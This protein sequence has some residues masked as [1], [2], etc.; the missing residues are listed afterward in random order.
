MVAIV[1]GLATG[2]E[3]VGSGYL[4]GPQ[5]ILTAEHCTRDKKT[6]GRPRYLRVVRASGGEVGQATVSEASPDVDLAVLTIAEPWGVDVPSVAFGRVDRKHS[7]ELRGCEAIGYP[8]WQLDAGDL[9][10][11]AAELHGTIRRTEDAEG[12]YLVLRDPLLGSVTTP[13]TANDADAGPGSVW[14]GLSGALVF[15][16]GRAIGVVVEHHPRQGASAVRLVPF[17]VVARRK[18]ARTRAVALALGLRSVSALPLVE[19]DVP[20]ARPRRIAVGRDIVA[21]LVVTGDRN[22]FYVGGHHRLADAYIPATEVFERVDVDGFV[23]RDWL[24]AELD[25]FLTDQDR[26]YFIV[27][28]EAGLGKTAFLAHLVRTRGWIHHFAETA[29]GEAGVIPSRLSLAAQ[30]IR[31]YELGGADGAGATLAEGPAARPDYLATL[32]RQ[33]AERRTPGERIVVV[34]DALDQAGARPGENVLGLP[35]RVPEGVFIICSQRPVPVRLLIDGSRR[36][37]KLDADSQHNL[38]DI[39]AFL[40]EAVHRPAIS[41][42]RTAAGIDEDQLI[43]EFLARSHGLWLYLHFVLADLASGSASVDLTALPDGLSRWYYE[44]FDRWREQHLADWDRV[45]LPVLA[46]LAAVQEPV[47]AGLLRTLA[48]VDVPTSLLSGWRPLLAVRREPER[49]YRLYHQSLVEFVE[50][51]FQPDEIAEQDFADDLSAATLAGHSR[52]ADRYITL[53]GGLEAGLTGL[54]EPAVRGVDGGYGL[55]HLVAHLAAAGRDDD[56]DS[57]LSISWRR[58]DDDK[59]IE[60]A[61]FA[62][63]DAAGTLPGFLGD[64]LIAVHGAKAAVDKQIEAGSPA[65]SVARELRYS[66]IASSIRGLAATVPAALVAALVRSGVWRADVAVALARTIDDPFLR[67]QQLAA[68]AGEPT[69]PD[70]RSVV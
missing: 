46:T 68:L 59:C 45:H 3:Q 56:L 58:A 69:L 23:G 40:Q 54:L 42:A 14:G 43:A 17:D 44:F 64:L 8:L 31:A 38:D 53:W 20:E 30:L 65:P 55:Q 51:H 67:Y 29:P 18:D 61:W 11:S 50:G 33:A 66:L 27:E 4:I 70:R 19:A 35:Q 16:A 21:Q 60:N 36:I 15:H 22:V 26:G 48:G 32:L 9:Q 28:A 24:E 52:I 62:A 57:V 10:R 37:Y 7:G 34:V 2:Q 41:A 12:D 5:L 49:S 13:V 39:A 47:N 1:A 63:H 25:G 6:G